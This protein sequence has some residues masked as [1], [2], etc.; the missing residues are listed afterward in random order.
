MAIALFSL[1]HV[2]VFVYWLG[3]DL[4]AFYASGIIADPK[5]S[6]QARTTAARFLND[7]DMAPRTAM[8]LALPTG[9][10]LASLKAWIDLPP[11]GLPA[12]WVGSVAW[13]ALAWII[14]LRHLA[15][16]HPGR[17][18]DLAIRWVVLTALTVAGVS[19][20]SGVVAGPLF[21]GLKLIVLAATIVCG[22]WVRAL[23]VPFG[24]A[25]G[26]MASGRGTPET[27][28]TITTS[29]ARV[30]PAVNLIWLLLLVAALLGLWMP[31]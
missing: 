26:Q 1:L 15:P 16:T 10:T 19:I 31:T 4:G 8:I 9:L 2:L 17:R 6:V 25:F 30:R 20:V 5:Q 3:G 11:W 29:L 7:L 18:M 13:L 28:Q 22:L 21:I 23:I 24:P 12:L 27:D 14:H